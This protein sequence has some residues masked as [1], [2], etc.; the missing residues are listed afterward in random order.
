MVPLFVG[1]RIAEV[2]LTPRCGSGGY[3]IRPYGPASGFLVGA[4]CM[5]AR[6]RV[7][8]VPAPV[9]PV[10]GHGRA[11]RAPTGGA[12]GG[13]ASDIKLRHGRPYSV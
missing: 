8:C 10:A 9:V 1:A 2:Q 4:A 7:R 13:G 3:E 5:A 6:N 11:M 12:F